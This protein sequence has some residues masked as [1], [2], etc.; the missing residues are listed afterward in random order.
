MKKWACGILILAAVFTGCA[1]RDAESA[2]G[3]EP[4]KAAMSEVVS[5]GFIPLMSSQYPAFPFRFDL[6][7]GQIEASC[8]AGLLIGFDDHDGTEYPTGKTL[9][10][11]EG[12]RLFWSPWDGAEVSLEAEIEFTISG[13]DGED[14]SGKITVKGTRN[15]L[16]DGEDAEGFV[17]ANYL[18]VL[19]EQDGLRMTAEPEGEGAVLTLA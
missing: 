8:S 3:T 1:G 19:E 13:S 15:A 6:P 2:A 18:A 16:E 14:Y 7:H 4:A 12:S 10:V 17:E 5:W 11:P 9:T